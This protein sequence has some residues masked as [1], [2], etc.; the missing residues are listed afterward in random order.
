[1]NTLLLIIIFIALIA[2]FGIT[3]LHIL[4]SIDDDWVSFLTLAYREP[5]YPPK[6]WLSNMLYDGAK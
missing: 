3:G 4:D 6:K 1:M 5:F 2:I